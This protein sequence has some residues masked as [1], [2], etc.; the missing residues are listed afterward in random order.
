MSDVGAADDE[1]AAGAHGERTVTTV[2]EIT[3][4]TTE[5]T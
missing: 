1:C 5:V 2:L 3:T 4:P